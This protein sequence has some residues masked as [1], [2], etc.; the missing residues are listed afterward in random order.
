MQF[1]TELDTAPVER[2]LEGLAQS[3][4]HWTE[5]GYRMALME[6][7]QIYMEFTQHRYADFSYGGG[8]WQPLS[9]SRKLER[10]YMLKRWQS[11]ARDKRASGSDS[12]IAADAMFFPILRVENS[13]RMFNSMFEGQDGNINYIEIL[14][15]EAMWIG[16]SSITDERTGEHYPALHQWG[17]GRPQRAVFVGPDAS[18]VERMNES[19]VRNMNAGM[20]SAIAHTRVFVQ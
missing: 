1:A 8:D 3:I 11:D 14:P 16:G 18:T 9:E 4:E 7:G 12:R 13:N 17:Q 2:D 10:Y 6:P 5:P 20:E 15:D 19:M